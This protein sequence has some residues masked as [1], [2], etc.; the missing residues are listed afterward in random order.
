[1]DEAR[2]EHLKRKSGTHP[3]TIRQKGDGEGGEEEPSCT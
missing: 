2:L 1:M 3:G